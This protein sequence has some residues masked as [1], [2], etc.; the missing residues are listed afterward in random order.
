MIEWVSWYGTIIMVLAV[1]AVPAGRA[2]NRRRARRHQ[3]R[4]YT[5]E[6]IYGRDDSV[7]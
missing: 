3:V 7:L 4:P 1:L 6:T 5:G 2:W